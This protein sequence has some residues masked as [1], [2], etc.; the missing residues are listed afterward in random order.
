[1]P[2]QTASHPKNGGYGAQQ[3]WTS[4]SVGAHSVAGT[5]NHQTFK[6]PVGSPSGVRPYLPT[7]S[8]IAAPTSVSKAHKPVAIKP[9]TY[10]SQ[11][12]KQGPQGVVS[13]QPNRPYPSHINTVAKAALPK[14]PDSGKVATSQA[15]P[16]ATSQAYPVGPAVSYNHIQVQSSPTGPVRAEASYKVATKN[17]LPQRWIPSYGAPRNPSQ[18]SD[19][20]STGSYP[21]QPSKKPAGHGSNI[22]KNKDKENESYSPYR[23]SPLQTAFSTTRKPISQETNAKPNRKNPGEVPSIIPQ[24][25]SAHPE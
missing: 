24:T 23:E 8:H 5:R 20:Q 2:L 18:Q 7:P 19:S 14:Q 15:H 4:G 6:Q 22:K 1:M 17:S 21:Q 3:P 16:A 25:I 11:Q 12:H 10:H 13:F 9:N